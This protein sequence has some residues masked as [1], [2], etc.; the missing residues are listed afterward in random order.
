MQS[1][2]VKINGL[3]KQITELKRKSAA[4]SDSEVCTGR[5]N[6]WVAGM[7]NVVV[8]VCTAWCV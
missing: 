8:G 7:W 5:T 2:R 3:E 6:L 1:M 4:S